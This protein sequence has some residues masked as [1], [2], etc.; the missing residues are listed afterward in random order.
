MT[1]A[2]ISVS[3]LA[4]CRDSAT[5]LVEC[6]A[7]YPEIS[8]HEK[9]TRAQRSKHGSAGVDVAKRD[10]VINISQNNDYVMQK[11]RIRIALSAVFARSQRRR[12][13]K[14][15]ICNTFLIHTRTKVVEA[16]CFGNSTLRH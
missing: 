7:D 3:N 5:A 14:N 4:I 2:N 9:Y 6:P 1:I 13:K 12:D 16:S 15:L 8:L 10:T 11:R